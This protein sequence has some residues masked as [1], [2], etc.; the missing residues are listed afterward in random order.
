MSS[1]LHEWQT[2]GHRYRLCRGPVKMEGWQEL[3]PSHALWVLRTGFIDSPARQGLLSALRRDSQWTLSTNLT[4]PSVLEREVELR[5]LV[6]L[7][8]PIAPLPLGRGPATQPPEMLRPRSEPRR[9]LAWIDITVV[10]DR[11]P[12]RPLARTRFRLSLPDGSVRE[13][14]L[15]DQAHLRV[16]DI[17]PGKC[18]LELRDLGRDFDA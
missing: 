1:V 9:E 13:G 10:D 18:W 16:D 4:V 11:V 6:L 7:D 14:V 17:E 8:Q 3:T 5:R 12:A 2:F 15:N